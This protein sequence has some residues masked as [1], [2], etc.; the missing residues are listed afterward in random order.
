MLPVMVSYH[1]H[2]H[3]H[4]FGAVAQLGERYVRNV[5]V[6]GSIPLSSTIV[7]IGCARRGVSGALNLQSAIAGSKAHS[8]VFP[9]CA[10]TRTDGAKGQV[11]RDGRALNPVRTGR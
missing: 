7:L 1:Q 10:D 2:Q 3:Q 5:Q 9:P 8:E 6:G 4:L 11:P